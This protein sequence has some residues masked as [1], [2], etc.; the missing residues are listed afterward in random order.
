MEKKFVKVGQLKE[1]GYLL[2]EGIACQIK[3]IEKSKP[4]KH[5]A[6]KARITAVGLF[7]NQKKTALMGTTDEGEVPIVLRGN[8]QVNAVMG[9]LLNLMDMESFEIFDASKPKDV[10]GI[11]QGDEVEYMKLDDQVRVLRRKGAE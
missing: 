10:T 8:A 9:D 7:N 1:G 3:S 5:G 2:I 6:A 11:K 4:G